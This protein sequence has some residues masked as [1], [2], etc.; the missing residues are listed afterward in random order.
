M[1]YMHS[2]SMSALER[3]RFHRRLPSPTVRRATRRTAGLSLQQVADH[4][5]VTRQSVANWERGFTPNDAALGLYAELL[6]ALAAICREPQGAG[7]R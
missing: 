7:L 1:L 2:I 5:G 6:E 3:A 4:C